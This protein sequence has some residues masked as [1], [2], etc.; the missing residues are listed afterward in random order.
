[1][2]GTRCRC[3]TFGI[4]GNGCHDGSNFLS[5]ISANWQAGRG[6][7]QNYKITTNESRKLHNYKIV[8]ILLT[9]MVS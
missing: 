7:Q 1:M 5:D 3:L 9:I 6:H 2:V 8:I 4:R